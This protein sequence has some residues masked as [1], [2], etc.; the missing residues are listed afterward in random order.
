MQKKT[1]AIL[2]FLLI[3]STASAGVNTNAQTIRSLFGG[4]KNGQIATASDPF[5]DSCGLWSIADNERCTIQAVSTL[6]GAEMTYSSTYGN[7][8]YGSLSQMGDALLISESLASGISHGYK[9]KVTVITSTQTTPAQ[10]RISAIPLIYGTTG[11]RSFFMDTG[12]VL[13]GADKNGEPATENDPFIDVCTQGSIV[14][15]ERCT[16][17]SLRTLHGAEMT[18]ASTYGNG[19]YCNSLAELALIG[20]I[21]PQLGL[22]KFRGYSFAVSTLPQTPTVPASFKITATPLVYGTTGITSFFIG[23][24]GVILGADKNGEPADENDPPITNK[25]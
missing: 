5:I 23:T 22:G 7:G 3:L 10:F 20:F 18:Y 12:G 13:Y 2:I 4:D 16:I 25:F 1:A 9:I 14:D 21:Q 15:N 8:N 17:D 6:H 11:M 19:S 24:D